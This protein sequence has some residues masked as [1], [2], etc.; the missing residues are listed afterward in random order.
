M[1]E[2]EEKGE[3]RVAYEHCHYV[4]PSLALLFPFHVYAT[5]KN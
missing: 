2:E 4:A 5:N 3:V 1:A